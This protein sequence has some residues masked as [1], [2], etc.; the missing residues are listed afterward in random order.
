MARTRGVVLQPECLHDLA[1]HPLLTAKQ[2][3]VAAGLQPRSAKLP[4]MMPAFQQSAVFLAQGP[5]D[6]PCSLVARLSQ[7]LTLRTEAQQ[8]V[9]VPKGA[10]FLRG[11]FVSAISEGGVKWPQQNHNNKRKLEVETD[12]SYRVVFRLPW[13]CK[14]FVEKAC[15]LGHPAGRNHAVPK[16][17]QVRANV[18]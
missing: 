17:L 18:G 8:P 5:S 13:D 6:I 9:V 1:D 14:Q 11:S 4:P 10:R 2:S 7:D 16:S 12:W 15:Q 3:Q